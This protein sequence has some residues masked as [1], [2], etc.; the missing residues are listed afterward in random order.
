[1]KMKREK[2]TRETRY[3]ILQRTLKSTTAQITTSSHSRTINT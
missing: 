1:M 3:T 2:K